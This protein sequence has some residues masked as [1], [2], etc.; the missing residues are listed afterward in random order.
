MNVEEILRELSD[1]ISEAHNLELV[2]ELTNIYV[3]LAD[4][5]REDDHKYFE[6]V[7]KSAEL[8]VK[9]HK[10]KE[11]YKRVWKAHKHAKEAFKAKEVY[12]KDL[13]T[14]RSMEESFNV[15]GE[16]YKKER[17]LRKKAERE[18]DQ[19]EYDKEYY[20]KE[21]EEERVLRSHLENVNEY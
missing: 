19:A 11:E 21:L 6:L 5:I 3:N 17:E 4:Q 16:M 9:R 14:K 12:K 18:R 20:A 15:V 10:Y 2:K 8:E 7:K 1:K 13:L